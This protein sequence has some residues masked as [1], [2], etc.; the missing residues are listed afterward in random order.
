MK[1]VCMMQ[2]RQ[3]DSVRLYVKICEADRQTT[4]VGNKDG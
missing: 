3:N 1:P 4:A 2:L